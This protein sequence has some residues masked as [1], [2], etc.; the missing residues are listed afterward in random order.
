MYLD[1]YNLIVQRDFDGGDCAARSGEY[2]FIK[3]NDNRFLNVIMQLE[4]ENG[5]W[6]RH[7]KYPD[8]K[9]MSRD[10]LDPLIIAMGV[11][12]N[13][14]ALFDT[15]KAH[16]KRGF[17]YQNGD[18]PMLA[19]FGLYIRAMKAWYLYPLLILSDLGFLFTFLTTMFDKNL[20][21]VDDN[22]TVMR[23]AQAIKTY[24]TPFSY[25][26]RKFYAITRPLN[27]GN[28]KMNEKNNVMGALVWYH[29]E[30]SG[31]NPEIAEAYRE[32]VEKYF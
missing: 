15:F 23:F 12:E 28:V 9:D 25:L 1:N 6:I 26:G 8:V 32:I 22:N 2:Y 17:L 18:L 4:I 19:T 30:E 10:Q 5:T 31:G 3:P 14:G 29:R 7:P 11:N 24:P 13:G 20:D 16:A 27:Y 21:H